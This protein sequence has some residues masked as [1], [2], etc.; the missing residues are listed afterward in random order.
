MSVAARAG[1]RRAAD[2]PDRAM[3]TPARYA[4]L[5]AAAFMGA[6]GL[7]FAIGGAFAPLQPGETRS[8]AL[9]ASGLEFVVVAGAV[10]VLL[11]KAS[12]RTPLPPAVGDRGGVRLPVRRAYRVAGTVSMLGFAGL[13]VTLAAFASSP[14]YVVVGALVG[15]AFVALSALAWHSRHD[16]W[17]DPTGVNTG[18]GT[19]RHRTVA[20]DDV[21]EVT[22]LDGWQPVLA[23]SWDA[24]D[25]AEVVTVRLLAQAWPPSTLIA[26]L[27]HYSGGKGRRDRAALTE[28]SSLDRFRGLR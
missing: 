4:F 5:A 12:Y 16:I 25:R 10:A 7:F 23:I 21:L 6:L 11:S 8:V 28:P 26:V 2:E 17:L 15:A 20:W 27:D 19:L 3:R 24:T 22:A 14:A 13:G 9:I 18:S 1:I